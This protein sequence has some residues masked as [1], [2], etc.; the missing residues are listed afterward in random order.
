MP[1]GG[2]AHKPLARRGAAGRRLRIVPPVR[3]ML[4][5]PLHRPLT[6]DTFPVAT[7][8]LLLLN[9]AIYFG[10]QLQDIATMERAQAHYLDVGLGAEEVPA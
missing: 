6:R 10:F 7:A 8:V 9:V 3:F 4:I 2:R 1:R 5:L